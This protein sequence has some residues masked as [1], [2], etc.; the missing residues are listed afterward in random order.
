[1]KKAL[2][3]LLIL[4]CAFLLLIVVITGIT[5]LVPSGDKLKPTAFEA[6]TTIAVFVVLIALLVFGL[7]KGIKSVKK[8]VLPQIIPYHKQLDIT[9]S[10][11]ISYRDY[12]NLIASITFKRGFVIYFVVIV[13]LFSTNIYSS[14]MREGKVTLP[15]LAGY[16]TFLLIVATV[17]LLSVIQIK[18]QYKNNKILNEY[19]T[20]RLTNEQLEITGETINSSLKWGHFYKMKE[21]R[22]FYLFYPGNNVAVILDK[23]MFAVSDLREL[24]EFLRSLNIQRS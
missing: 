16:G 2:W 24:W 8:K 18:K 1:M 5:L 10:G 23:R 15:D 17:I 22:N 3:W 19:L 7:V 13:L 11:Q 4:V 9:G 20:Y 21:I 14:Y 6:Y 12:R